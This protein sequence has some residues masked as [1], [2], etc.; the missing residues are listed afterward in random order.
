MDTSVQGD[1]ILLL[2]TV[3]VMIM[4]LLAF[5]LVAFFFL[6]Q[7]K[8]T[9]ERQKAYAQQ[10]EHREQLLYSTLQTQEDERR[11][12]AKDLHDDVGSKLNVLHLNL[13]RL[14][15][16]A[17]NTPET[18]ETIQALFHVVH[19]TI[20]TTRR[21][22]HDLLPPAL[23]SFGLREA[24][25]E[26]CEQYRRSGALSLDFEAKESDAGPLDK[27][28]AIHLFR[29]VQELLSNSVKHGRAT[30]IFLQLWRMPTELRIDYRDNG[31]GFD[32]AG[33]HFKPGLGIQNIESRMRMIGAEFQLESAPGAGFRA[34][35]KYRYPT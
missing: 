32:P 22:S 34:S 35:I 33:A 19:T 26:L 27:T 17:A 13:H 12:I 30:H 1:E 5:S 18:A 10:L 9:N 21:I 31:R 8:L 11:R 24:L 20:D 28:A 7:R 23:E 14:Q 2:I 6:S 16:Q 15:K 3:G 29:V 25:S 4:L